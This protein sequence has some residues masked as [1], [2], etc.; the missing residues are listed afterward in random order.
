MLL[1]REQI[2]VGRL[3]TDAGQHWHGGLEEFV[4][5]A[6]P[7]SGQI[8]LPVDDSRFLRSRLQYVVD[9]AHTD[10]DAQQVAQEFNDAATRAAANQRQR[11]DHLAHPGLGDRQLEQNFIV[12][13]R[14]PESVVQ[15]DAGLVRLLV[16][17]LAAH[18]MLVRQI[19]DRL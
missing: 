15:R 1:C 19:A 13:R 14:Q 2:A 17:E 8:L 7:N 5:Q 9:A 6:D 11:D 12:R 10:R 16:D 3:G 18:P 4:V